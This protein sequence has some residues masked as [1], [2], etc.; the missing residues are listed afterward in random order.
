MKQEAPKGLS[1][2]QAQEILAFAK[3]QA[4][5]M[6]HKLP[7]LGPVTWLMMQQ[8]HTR[9]TLLSELEWRVIPALMLDQA[10][11]FYAELA[12]LVG[13]FHVSDQKRAGGK[14]GADDRGVESAR[15]ADEDMTVR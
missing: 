8:A 15:Q 4:Q 6:F 9:H 13:K 14:G 1:E 3:D 5:Q 2:E 10:R 11:R 7:M 12:A